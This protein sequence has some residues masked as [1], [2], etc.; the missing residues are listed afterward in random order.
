V[1]PDPEHLR[2][3]YAEAY[4]IAFDWRDLGQECDM[5]DSI[6][7]RFS[8]TGPVPRSFLDLCCGPGFHCLEYARRGLRSY[9][10]DLSEAML[11]YAREKAARLGIPV[12]FIHAD[13]RDFQLPASVD[14]AFCPMGSFHYLL[15]NEDIV[16]NLQAVARNLAPG[17]LYVIEANHPRNVFKMER[18][19]ILDW[20]TRINDSV[21]PM[22]WSGDWESQ[23][24]ETVVRIHWG[25]DDGGYDPF[26]QIATSRVRIEMVRN[27]SSRVWEFQ[28]PDRFLTFQELQLLIEKSGVF[29]TLTW[30]GD[31]DMDCPLDN[32]DKSSWMIPVLRRR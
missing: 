10:L 9:G 12:G 19:H 11:G 6:F 24:G 2:H 16:R 15:S 31:L 21:V 30:L 25:A 8:S 20:G 32:S 18:P 14:L 22:S 3:D 1:H 26:S 29:E 7:R 13:M 5:L 27:G 17:G 28:D 4:D 23:R